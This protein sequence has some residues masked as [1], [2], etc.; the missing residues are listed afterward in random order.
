MLGQGGMGEVW[1]AMLQGPEGFKK[2]VALKL[3]RLG[4]EDAEA[5]ASLV[6]EAK[7]GALLSHPNVVGI[8]SLGQAGTTWYVAMELVRGASFAELLR[9]LGPLPPSAV[10]DAGIQACAGLHHVHRFRAPG[11]HVGLVH[12]DVKPSNLLVDAT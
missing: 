11:Q 5:R 6:R 3:L 9:G 10:L 8:Y 1:E 7:L 4:P 2:P 12:R